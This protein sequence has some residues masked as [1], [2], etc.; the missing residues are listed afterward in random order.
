MIAQGA[1]DCTST[2]ISENY[3]NVVAT[4]GESPKG[5]EAQ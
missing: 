3:Q 2:K 5:C 4:E 1:N